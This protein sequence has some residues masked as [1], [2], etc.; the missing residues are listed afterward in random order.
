MYI[1]HIAIW[2][3]D[4]EAVKEFY[5]RYFKCTAG[6]KYV[7]SVKGFSSYFLSFEEGSRIELMKKDDINAARK[8]ESLG[9]AHL[10][11]N[12][13]SREEVDKLT[14]RVEKDGN[15]ILGKPRMT[16]DGY[17]ESIILDPEGNMVEIMAGN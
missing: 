6:K 3:N 2:T 1:D 13:G 12:I 9:L 7:N 4:I 11:I 17:Y 8:G 15:I 16:G 14:E 10:S 5:L